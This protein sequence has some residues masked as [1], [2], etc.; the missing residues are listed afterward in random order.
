MKCSMLEAK[1]YLLKNI[2]TEIRCAGKEEINDGKKHELR[3]KKLI[4]STGRSRS[5]SWIWINGRKDMGKFT[6]DFKK[7]CLRTVTM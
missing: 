4:R 3:S 7:I 6:L 2:I 5:Y 1:Q